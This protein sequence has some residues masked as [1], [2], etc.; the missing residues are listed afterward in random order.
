M[1]C[2]WLPLL[3]WGNHREIIYRAYVRNDMVVWQQT[4]VRMAA[5]S[6]L[7]V[8]DKMEL[9]NYYYG[10]IGWA[11]G[12]MRTDE[13]SQYLDDAW[14][15]LEELEERNVSLSMTSAYRSAFYGFAIGLS[16][17]KAPFFGPRSITSVKKALAIDSLN[18]FAT[19]QYAHV[20]YYMPEIFGG[21][22]TQALSLYVRSEQIY[23]S[24]DF[25][26]GDWNYLNLLVTIGRVYDEMN[27]L[28]QAR[29]Y[30]EKAMFVEPQFWWVKEKLYPELLKR[31]APQ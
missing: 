14:E 4:M 1:A 26:A 7:S 27:N 23:E 30:Y 29:R 9:L 12:K 22:K 28:A 8:D 16:S 25:I 13:A 18:W 6:L 15:L 5:S 2:W 21:S 24:N 31:I 10:Y 17:Y 20:L 19:M 3:L 11:I